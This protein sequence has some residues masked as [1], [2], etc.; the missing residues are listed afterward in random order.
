MFTFASATRAEHG[1]GRSWPVL[2]RGHH[3]S[4]FLLDLEACVDERPA[5]PNGI[6]DKDVVHPLPITHVAA[7][8]LDV[9]ACPTERVARPLECARLVQ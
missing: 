9:D 6:L 1:C 2:Y 3:D 7:C 4:A 8:S 5:C